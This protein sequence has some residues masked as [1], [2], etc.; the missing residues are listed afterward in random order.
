MTISKVAL[1]ARVSKADSD[2]DPE[3][4]LVKLRA[5]AEMRGWTVYGEY[6]DEKSG[7]DASRP[8]LVRML[9]AAKGH[10]FGAILIVR[11]DRIGRSVRNLHNLL[12]ELQHFGIDLICSD[13]SYDTSTPVG[14]LLRNVLADISEFELELIR[15]RTKDG[16]ARARARG[17]ALG[18]PQSAIPTQ[19]I[20]ELR[21]QGFSLNKIAK[22]VGMSHQ[23]VKKR[24]VK[25]G[26]TKRV[27]NRT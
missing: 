1:Y 10:A 19:R 13:Q 12:A 15:E 2:Q 18:R 8:D 11:L 27:E 26:V 3:N 9:K 14:R 21:S 23:G 6:I 4:Q 25:A 5:F 7:T 17:I 22:E 24:L 20:V 16:L